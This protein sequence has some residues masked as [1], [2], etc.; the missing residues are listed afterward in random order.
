MRSPDEL[1]REIRHRG[2]EGAG[3]SIKQLKETF[4]TAPQVIEDFEKQ[5]LVLVTRGGKEGQMKFVFWNE[6]PQESGGKQIESGLSHCLST[7]R[8]CSLIC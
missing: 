4:P 1:L 7:S 8:C 5:G 6:I 3:I 2:Q